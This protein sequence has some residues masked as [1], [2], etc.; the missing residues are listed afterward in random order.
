MTAVRGRAGLLSTTALT[1][2]LIC[3]VGACG[4]KGSANSPS[5]ETTWKEPAAYTY[6]LTSS[7]GERSLIGTFRITVRDGEVTEAVGLDDSARRFVAQT[8]DQVPTLGALLAELA[9]ARRDAADTAEAEYATD[10]HPARIFLD[11]DEN[12]LDDEARYVVEAYEPA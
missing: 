11:W 8:P 5:E 3:T 4:T 7:E 2:A 1:A 6:T 9:Q 10:G 12:A